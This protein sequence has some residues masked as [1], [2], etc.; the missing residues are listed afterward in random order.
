[1]HVKKTVYSNSEC[2]ID[3]AKEL[4]V[5]LCICD[6]MKTRYEIAGFFLIAA[7]NNQQESLVASLKARHQKSHIMTVD[8]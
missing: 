5:R 4:V 2:N 1:M 8:T 6:V 3:V 7:L